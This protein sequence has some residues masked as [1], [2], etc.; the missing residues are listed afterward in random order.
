MCKYGTAEA[1]YSHKIVTTPAIHTHVEW[2]LC[3]CFAKGTWVEVCPQV[4]IKPGAT[5]F[6]SHHRLLWVLTETQCDHDQWWTNSRD[7]ES[8]FEDIL[9]KYCQ[10]LTLWWTKWWGMYQDSSS[11]D[12]LC[13]SK[14]A[15]SNLYTSLWTTTVVG[16]LIQ[17]STIWPWQLLR[18]LYFGRT[19]KLDVM[20]GINYKLQNKTGND[21]KTWQ[22]KSKLITVNIIDRTHL[23]VQVYVYKK[24]Q[25]FERI[26]KHFQQ[27]R[28]IDTLAF[29][30]VL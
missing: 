22:D 19:S 25:N 9:L 28:A 20:S 2:C 12:T 14:T 18:D 27:Q 7:K 11:V 3:S 4:T 30:K 23:I 26:D 29:L 8:S 17:L 5:F 10:A 24:G 15:S 21:K 16:P 13:G 1:F 6:L